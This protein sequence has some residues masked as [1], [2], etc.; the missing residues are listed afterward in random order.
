[1][2]RSNLYQHIAL[3]GDD[4]G[5]PQL[6]SVVPREKIACIVG[7]IIRP[8]YFT[9]LKK[10]AKMIGCSFLVQPKKTSFEY[11]SFYSKLM[12]LG[13][14]L[15]FSN[16][17]SMKIHRD[18][19]NLVRNNAINI[20]ESLLPKNRGFNPTQWAIIK[21]E[22]ET[23]VTMHYMSV[24]IDSGDIIAQKRVIISNE[25]T[26]VSVTDKARAAQVRLI[27][28]VVPEILTGKAKREKQNRELVSQNKRLDE[29]YPKICF[30]T[31]TNLQIFNL[32]RA[33]VKPLKGAYIEKNG[34]RKYFDTY[35]P[36]SGITKLRQIYG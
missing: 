19:L 25:D 33:Q 5:I 6:L 29:H 12:N 2:T 22:K 15:L 8:Q 10:S 26:W 1:M 9:Y 20:H 28:K 18:V 4:Y 36:Y 32:I 17:Y 11:S 24:D 27:R 3:F 7:A 31:M 23:G 30:D 14:D 13:I 21:G 34:K 16:S 35:V